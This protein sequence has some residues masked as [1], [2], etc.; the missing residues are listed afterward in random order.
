MKKINSRT[1]EVTKM[2]RKEFEDYLVE[3]LEEIREVYNEYCPEDPYLTMTLH[4]GGKT[5]SANNTYWEKW[6]KNKVDVWSE[7]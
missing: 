3:K 5:I 1:M 4:S 7:K 6:C 2:T